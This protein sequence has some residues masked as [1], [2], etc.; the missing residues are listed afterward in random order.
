MKTTAFKQLIFPCFFVL[1]SVFSPFGL[2]ADEQVFRFKHT[3]G[4]QYRIIS[5]VRED[6]FLNGLLSHQ[7]S[8]TNKVSVRINKVSQD[9]TASITAKFYLTENINH[10]KYIFNAITK[11]YTSH[12][13]R[14]AFGFY[15]DDAEA[16][17]PV[18]RN[19]P[20]FPERPLH[21]DD[22]WTQ[23]GYEV[24]DLSGAPFFLKTPYRFPIEVHYTYL[25]QTRKKGPLLDIFT[26][27]YD[28][29]YEDPA[30]YQ[31]RQLRPCRIFGRSEQTYLWDNRL[32]RPHSYTESFRL[33]LQ[34]NSGSEAEFIG[35]ANAVVLNSPALDRKA[36][37]SEINR[38]LD[39]KTL[40]FS[41]QNKEEGVSI[42]LNNILFEPDSADMLPGQ[43]AKL[44]Q[45]AA[46]LKRHPERDIL[47][48]G[49]TALAGTPEAQ[50]ALSVERAVAVSR[51]LLNRKVRTSDRI[52]IDGKGATEPVAS[53]DT[54]AGK[55]QNRRVEIIILEN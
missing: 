29:F 35:T 55:R 5:T 38:D 25:G 44:D 2:P 19:V 4:D 1:F 51:E 26:I 3:P 28:V 49:H 18:V 41:V 53:N 22:T 30:G 14:N 33:K 36:L 9:E 17:M 32:G 24:H 20:L 6:A 54:E 42:S 50:E 16:F 8:I 40:D 45:I 23:T 39:P 48:A 7:S 34:D 27:S 37:I 11:N 21:I 12:F 52:F 46:V 31:T 10:Q 47:V 43:D 13:K 15:S